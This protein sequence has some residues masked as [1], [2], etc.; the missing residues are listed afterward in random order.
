MKTYRNSWGYPVRKRAPRLPDIRDRW[1]GD[2][3]VECRILDRN[4][5]LLY[6]EDTDGSSTPGWVGWEDLR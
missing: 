4:G 6:V 1:T 2:A 5:T 3:W